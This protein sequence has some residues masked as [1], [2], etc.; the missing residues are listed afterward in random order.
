MVTVKALGVVL[1][2]GT[3]R[4]TVKTASM[5][6]GTAQVVR[7]GTEMVTVTG[8]VVAGLTAKDMDKKL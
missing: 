6:M 3:V 4:A 2:S 8:L 1:G 5:G 7:P